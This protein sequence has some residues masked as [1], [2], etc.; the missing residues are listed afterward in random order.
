[1]NDAQFRRI[2]LSLLGLSGV[3]LIVS[4]LR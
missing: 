4:S 3:T 2:I 1:V